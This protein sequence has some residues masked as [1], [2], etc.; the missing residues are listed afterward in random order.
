MKQCTKIKYCKIRKRKKKKHQP[1][2]YMDTHTHTV[3]TYE[4]QTLTHDQLSQKQTLLSSNWLKIVI[5]MDW[6]SALCQVDLIYHNWD[7]CRFFFANKIRL[8]M[9]MIEKQTVKPLEM[10]PKSRNI[11]TLQTHSPNV[12]QRNCDYIWIS[13]ICSR[14]L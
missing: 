7:A 8:H 2:E 10:L 4:Q 1:T 14:F 5:R 6:Y 11:L 13:N 9:I 3:C 12:M